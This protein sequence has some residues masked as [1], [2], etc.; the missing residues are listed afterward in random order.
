[1]NHCYCSY[2]AAAAV[3]AAV[4]VA[5]VGV[6]VASY[7]VDDSSMQ[8]VAVAAL[9]ST[10]YGCLIRMHKGKKKACIYTF[11]TL[12]FFYLLLLLRC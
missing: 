5:A 12:Y 3:A 1:M 11:F 6:A 2:F 10:V 9:S 4:A 8:H 7:A